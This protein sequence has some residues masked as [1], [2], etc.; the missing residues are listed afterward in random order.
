MEVA[1][2]FIINGNPAKMDDDWGYPYL[3]KPPYIKL[4]QATPR[5][6]RPQLLS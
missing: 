1:G 2:W 6:F 4:Y 5:P 3:R